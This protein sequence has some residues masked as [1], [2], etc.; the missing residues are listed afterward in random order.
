[1]SE[2]VLDASAV[3]ALLLG[4]PGAGAVAAVL[5]GA[6]LSTVNLAE[7]IGKLAERGMPAEEASR[8]VKMLGVDIVP[9]TAAQ[10]C[11]AGA[12]RPATK[13][14]GLALGDR[15]CLALAAERGAKALTADK[16]WRAL[17]EAVVVR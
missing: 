7:I 1:M 3:L 5:P 15:A 17:P 16:A 2:A 12:L 4:E 14:L 9:F 8:A 6:L 11:A 13:T 10:A